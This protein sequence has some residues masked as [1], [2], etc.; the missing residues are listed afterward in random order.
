MDPDHGGETEEGRDVV[1]AG[2]GDVVV[3]R[4]RGDP[5]DGWGLRGD[6]K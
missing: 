4:V 1:I 5:R 6:R 3:V 2:D